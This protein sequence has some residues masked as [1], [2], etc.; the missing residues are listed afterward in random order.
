MANGLRIIVWPDHDIPN[1]VMYNFV[2][3]GGRNEYPGITGLSHFFEHMMFNGTTSRKPGEFDRAMEAVGG[4]NNAYTTNDLTVY[5]GWFPR[6]ALK[7]ILE[8]EADR[9]QNLAIDPDVVERER[10]VV[11]SERRLR[12][13]NDNWGRLYEQVRAT[14]FVAHPYQFPVIGWPS[15]IESWTQQDLESYFKTYY[16][17]NNS[18]M[19]FSGA[20][21]PEEIFLLAEQYFAPIPRQLPPPPVRTIEPEQAGERRLVIEKEAQTPLLHLAFHAGRAAD[22]ETQQMQLLLN[23]LT[24]GN[25]SRL[26]RL[27]VEEEQIA[28]SV[29]G[30][31][32][33]GFDPGL[34]YI[35]LTLPPGADIDAV[36]ARVLEELRRVAVE[37]VTRAELGKARNIVLADFWREIATINGKASAL[38]DFDVFTGSYENLFSLPEDVKA[39][40]SQQIQA[41]AAKV[42]QQ[43]NMTVG[44]LRSPTHTPGAGK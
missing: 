30:V 7:T 23:I 12:V 27:L 17:P 38:G 34:V 6:S 9:L 25:S 4:A 39:I 28:L 36:E 22:P 16:A 44:V 31:Q 33:Q 35:Y 18:T 3:A 11:Y 37:G 5:Q 1:V 8:L 41:V 20:V 19:V 29:A 21:S 26:H 42:F 24:D 13:D 43:N 15:D 40:T 10:G 32:I 2:R 14:A